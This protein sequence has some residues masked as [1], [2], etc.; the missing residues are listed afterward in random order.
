MIARVTLVLKPQ[1]RK[2][3]EHH[4]YYG[5]EQGMVL[6][7][8]CRI[9]RIPLPPDDDASVKLEIS[10]SVLRQLSCC[11]VV[12]AL[13]LQRD[14][15]VSYSCVFCTVLFSLHETYHGFNC[16]P[17]PPE[18]KCW[19]PNSLCLR[20]WERIFR[21]GSE[22]REDLYRGSQAKVRSSG[23]TLIRCD[24]CSYI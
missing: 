16:V 24:D 12:C 9:L 8:V 14:S 15:V 3:W 7:G 21:R 22:W 23:W 2:W 6:Q 13:T 5:A 18:F 1:G 19:S 4:E 11:L 20:K 17:L 10:G